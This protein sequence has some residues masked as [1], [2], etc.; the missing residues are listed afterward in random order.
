[1]R[2]LNGYVIVEVYDPDGRTKGGIIV[3]DTAKDRFKVGKIVA[4]ADEII[5][6]S[7]GD[8]VLFNP[9]TGVPVPDDTG[10]VVIRAAD[11]MAVIYP[12]DPEGWGYQ[13]DEVVR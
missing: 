12:F 13:T 9:W 3:P 11:C 1:M 7:P 2:P 5:E 4:V 8:Y 10:R 6:P